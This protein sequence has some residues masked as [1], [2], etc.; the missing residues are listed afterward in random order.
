MVQYV[1]RAEKIKSLLNN[2]SMANKDSNKQ[3]KNSVSGFKKLR[4]LQISP[5]AYEIVNKAIQTATDALEEDDCGRF[6]EAIEKYEKTID[7][8]TEALKSKKIIIFL[9]FLYE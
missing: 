1:E 9:Y 4:K 6:K 8:F 5:V 3:D 7:L 2:S